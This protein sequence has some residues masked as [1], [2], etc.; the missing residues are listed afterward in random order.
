MK[1]QD[2]KNISSLGI[3]TL[4][5][6]ACILHLYQKSETV[7]RILPKIMAG[8]FI[9]D[10]P[11]T[12]QLDFQIHHATSIC[13]LMYTYYYGVDHIEFENIWYHL[14]KTEISTIFLIFR[15]YLPKNT[16]LYN[17]N[18]SIFYV[19]F[20]KFRMIDLYVHF[21][22]PSSNIY[23]VIQKYTPHNPFVSALFISCCYTLYGV[24]IYW[25]FIMNQHLYHE[26]TRTKK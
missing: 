15:Y 20:T 6:G 24:N 14:M 1:L 18:L 5:L 23:V 9:V 17:T 22:G 3:C 2:Y 8:Y 13:I 21:V 19:T 26:I 10:L 7:F 4:C 16:L 25:Y 12:S 11:I